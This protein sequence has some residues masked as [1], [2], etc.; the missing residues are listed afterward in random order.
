[1]PFL[2]CPMED[3]ECVAPMK[4]MFCPYGHMTEC[5][6]PL[7]CDE[8]ECSHYQSQYQEDGGIEY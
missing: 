8:A 5:H 7:T 6:F 3:N 2:E 4:C 1:M